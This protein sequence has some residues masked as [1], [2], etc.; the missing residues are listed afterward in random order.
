MSEKERGR[1]REGGERALCANK[2]TDWSRLSDQRD[3]IQTRLHL[4]CSSSHQKLICLLILP[5]REAVTGSQP[6]QTCLGE[7]SILRTDAVS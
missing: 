2:I 5:Y 4:P 6:V 3:G 1:E 7:D